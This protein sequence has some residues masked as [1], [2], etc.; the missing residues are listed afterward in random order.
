MRIFLIRHGESTQN[1]Q[2]NFANLPDF[3]VS[4]TEK[5]QEEANECGKFLKAFCKKNNIDLNDA[6]MYVS[7]FERTRQTAKLVNEHL[8]IGDVE[9]DPILIERQFGLFDNLTSEQRAKYKEAFDYQNWMY[10]NGG[11]FF[12]KFPLGESNFDVYVRARMFLE[13]LLKNLKSD[14]QNIFIISHGA[15]LKNFQMAYFNYSTE[16]FCDEPF[17]KNCSVK[18]I[19]KIDNIDYDREYIYGEAKEKNW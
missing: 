3:K 6:K 2:T 5:G 7:P 17:M 15:F 16:W 19:E 14:D 10:E 4:L 13:K 18:L 1:A 12:T 8:N 9:E 11:Y